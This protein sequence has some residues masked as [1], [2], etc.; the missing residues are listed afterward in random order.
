M[1]S[2]WILALGAKAEQAG[3]GDERPLKRFTD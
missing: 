3:P 2:L 1:V